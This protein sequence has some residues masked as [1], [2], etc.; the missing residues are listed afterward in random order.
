MTR[1]LLNPSTAAAAFA[2]ADCTLTYLNVNPLN[3]RSYAYI[4]YIGY[5]GYIG[6]VDV[7]CP[8]CTFIYQR[9]PFKLP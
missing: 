6:H 3:R 2:P 9:Q 7:F 4:A 1:D 8:R 5:I